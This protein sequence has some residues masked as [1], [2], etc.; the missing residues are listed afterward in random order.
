MFIDQLSAS[1]RGLI[2]KHIA[3]FVYWFVLVSFLYTEITQITEMQ[4]W[5][6]TKCH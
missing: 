3:L 1:H 2:I 4:V 6:I 5:L